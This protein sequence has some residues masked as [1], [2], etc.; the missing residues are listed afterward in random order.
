MFAAVDLGSNSF[1]LH[2]GF[3][4]GTAIR[5]VKTARDPIRLGAGLDSN[6]NL[7][8]AAM[9]DALRCLRN[10]K[11][12]LAEYELQAMRVV[13]WH[14]RMLIVGFASGTW[15]QIP[16]NIVLVKNIAVMSSL[17]GGEMERDPA[18]ARMVLNEALALYRDGQLR[19]LPGKTYPLKDAAD[20]LRDMMS[21]SITG[22]SV[23][24][25]RA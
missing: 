20:A 7:T 4:D 11:G 25:P 2:I 13:G 16:A 15:Q 17:W 5:V 18:F 12:I 14:A 8:E 9:Q 24:L 22:K 6:G 23:V 19:P 1:R 21:R 3:H 10:F